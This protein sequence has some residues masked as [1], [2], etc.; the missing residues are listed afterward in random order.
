MKLRIICQYWENYAAMNDDW[1][2]KREGWK[3]KGGAEFIAAIPDYA[4]MLSGEELKDISIKVISK[5][6]NLHVKYDVVETEIL[7]SDPTD[8]SEEFMKEIKLQ[9]ERQVNEPDPDDKA[10]KD[11]RDVAEYLDEKEKED[12]EE[13]YWRG[14]TAYLERNAELDRDEQEDY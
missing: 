7:F 1:D 9:Y 2:G 6:S 11:E 12:P 10:A 4:M 5:H 13:R 8:V 3:P 14:H